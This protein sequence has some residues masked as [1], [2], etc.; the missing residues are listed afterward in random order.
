[1]PITLWN[2]DLSV[3]VQGLDADHQHLI[4]T[5]NAV[6]DALIHGNS[7]STA[8]RAIMTLREYMNDHFLREEE[9]MLETAYAGFER[10][11]LEHDNLR[12]QVARLLE[13][14]AQSDDQ[15]AVELLVVLRD[16]LLGHIA[17]SD[18]AAAS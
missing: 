3:G 16:W 1:M 12:Q 5:M 13:L 10:H 18:K 8:L 14:P 2:S 7:A 17:R 11:K 4:T 6:F 15:L 9:W